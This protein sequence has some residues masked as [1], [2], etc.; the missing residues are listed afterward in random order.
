MD[1]YAKNAG[2]KAVHT[3]RSVAQ[4]RAIDLSLFALIL[5]VFETV[6]VRAATGW[7]PQEPWTVSATAAV[8]A[9]VMVRWGPWGVLHA[10]LGGIVFCL[11]NRGAPKQYLIY[12]LG[13]TASLAVLPLLKKWGWE[14]LRTDI[15]KNLCY[16]FL[17]LLLMQAGRAAVSL[18]TGASPAAAAGFVTT[19]VI[20]YIFTLTLVWIASRLDG[21]LEDQRHYLARIHDPGNREGG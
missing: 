15:L 8:T 5:I 21:I 17:T 7:F 10:V 16:G 1:K 14:K 6:L 3:Q 13:N 18:L 2:G 9:I 19:D 12:C 4:Y 11:V 20:T